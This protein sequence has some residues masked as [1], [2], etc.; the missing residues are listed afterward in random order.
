MLT[1]DRDAMTAPAAVAATAAPVTESH[2]IAALD[3]LRGIAVLGILLMN[4]WVFGINLRGDGISVDSGRT[5]TAQQS[6]ALASWREIELAFIPNAEDRA[7]E[8]AAMRGAY[9]EV[10]TV[11]RKHALE[12]ETRLLPT[13]LGDN[14][15]LML[16]GMA[17]LQWGFFTARW[18]SKA[19]MW[20]MAIG[21]GLGLPLVTFSFWYGYTHTP[22][23]AA[24]LAFLETHPIYWVNLIYPVQRI[25]LVMAH[26]SL[27]M[28]LWQ[29]GAFQWLFARLRAVGQMALTNY[30][31]QSVLCTLFFFGYGLGFYERLAVHQVYVVVVAVW[32]LQLAYSPIWL[33]HFR[34]GPMEWL[35]RSLTYWQAQPMW[36]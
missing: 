8:I 22:D 27:L 36:R 24:F 10:G 15:A 35:W 16:L 7:N 25:L 9:G 30:L 17:L 33:K 13:Q 21:Y 19:Y 6:A 32:A 23:T 20:T 1:E 3:M 5:L 29:K 14:I 18:T 12:W 2:R 26:C 4:I 11:V 31:M 34:F 28:V